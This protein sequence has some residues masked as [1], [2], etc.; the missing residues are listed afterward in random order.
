MRK[1]LSIM[2]L[3][4]TQVTYK[5]TSIDAINDCYLI[6]LQSHWFPQNILPLV[7]FI[8]KEVFSANSTI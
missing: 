2:S 8:S 7:L 6:I 5:I 1:A 4:I 3:I